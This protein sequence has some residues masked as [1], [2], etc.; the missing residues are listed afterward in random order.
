MKLVETKI[1][2]KHVHMRYADNDD[3]AKAT[4]WVDI[5]VPIASL[6]LPAPSGIEIALG[7]P[8][9][10]LLSTIKQ[11]ALRYARDEII[12]VETQRLASVPGTH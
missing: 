11:A 5:Q 10:R 2:E 1:L 4:E 9:T 7:N 3:P 8:E 12:G 6:K